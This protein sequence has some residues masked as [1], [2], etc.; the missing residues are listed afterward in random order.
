MCVSECV[1]AM[2]E[3]VLSVYRCKKTMLPPRREVTSPGCARQMD[4]QLSLYSSLFA[5][6]CLFRA[7]L[8]HVSLLYRG[9][10][11]KRNRK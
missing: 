4:T 11:G 5:S 9:G 10:K 6:F 7:P 2:E 8:C 3:G 1:C